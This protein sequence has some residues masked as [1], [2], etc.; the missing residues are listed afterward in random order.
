M[1]N[2]PP[3]RPPLVAALLSAAP[4]VRDV[5][6]EHLADNDGDVLEY[7]FLGDVAVFVDEAD[8]EGRHDLVR[9][10]L[11][12]L[13]DALPG[14]PDLV[15]LGF[16]ENARWANRSEFLETWPPRLREEAVRQGY[17]STR[18]GTAR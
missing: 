5:W 8:N 17:L 12:V 2:Q 4:E 7:V 18:R 15:A 9:R 3:H 14:A 11:S 13:D 10:V 16:V 1:T 6:E